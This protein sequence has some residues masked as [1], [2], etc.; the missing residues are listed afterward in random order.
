MAFDPLTAVFSLI[1]TGIDKFLPKK[2]DEAEKA[3]FV[4]QMKIHAATEARNAKSD[5]RQFVLGYE[6]AAKDV[7][8]I[9]VII[10]SL[11]RPV[12]T[13]MV[14]VIDWFYFTGGDTAWNAE[15]ISLLKGIN[16]IVLGFWFGERALQ[17][18]GLIDVMKIRA[19]KSGEAP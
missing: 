5:F 12:F 9:V 4:Q 6:G 8:R 1:E 16:Y 7:P 17:R 14:G 13:V 10:R 18:S 3:Q 2:M 11:I 19:E 15:T